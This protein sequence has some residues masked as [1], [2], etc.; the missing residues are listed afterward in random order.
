M[1]SVSM[2]SYLLYQIARLSFRIQQDH[3]ISLNSLQHTAEEHNL[4]VQVV[5]DIWLRKMARF[6]EIYHKYRI[7]VRV[8]LLFRWVY[9]GQML[10]L[11]FPSLLFS[12]TFSLI[13]FSYSLSSYILPPISLCFLSSSRILIVGTSIISV[14]AVGISLPE[15][16]KVSSLSS[17]SLLPF[18]ISRVLL[19]HVL[20]VQY[21]EPTPIRS[22]VHRKL[23]ISTSPWTTS[24]RLE[25]HIERDAVW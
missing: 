4:I 25:D 14:A 1:S 22:Q 11:L 18:K 13:L 8:Y 24:Q 7:C 17:I 9:L 6:I 10:W 15:I 21:H 12:H 16:L 5:V 20:W 23:R 3:K 2:R 19:D